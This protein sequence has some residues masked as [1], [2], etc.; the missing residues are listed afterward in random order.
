MQGRA[1]K[2]SR[3]EN[4]VIAMKISMKISLLGLGLIVTVL[5]TAVML[6]FI[7]LMGVDI[8]KVAAREFKNIS[9]DS[10]R[11]VAVDIRQMCDI[12]RLF[13]ESYSQGV[14]SAVVSA[15]E[16]FGPARL[17]SDEISVEAKNQYNPLQKIEA[18]VK[19]F[20]FGDT[21]VDPF[22]PLDSPQ[23]KLGS[24]L[25]R[26]KDNLKCDFTIF[27][28]INDSKNML[29]LCSTLNSEGA[30]PSAMTYFPET[31][32]SGDGNTAFSYVLS[33]RGYSGIMEVGLATL[34]ANYFPIFD[35]NGEVI[36]AVFY[37]TRKNSIAELEKYLRSYNLSLNSNSRIWIIDNSNE[38]NPVIKTSLD[39]SFAGVPLS[40]DMLGGRKKYL[41]DALSKAKSLRS[42]EIV[43]ENIADS[44]EGV[45][46]GKRIITYTYYRPWNWVIGAISTADAYNGSL[47]S[48]SLQISRLKRE[49]VG[50]GIFFTALALGLSWFFASK[51]ARPLKLMTRVA[52]A[53][54]RGDMQSAEDLLSNSSSAGRGGITEFIRL[55]DALLSMTRNISK[56][57]SSV[58]RTGEYTA[59][60]GMQISAAATRLESM[61]QAENDAI[62]K[63]SKKGKQIALSYDSLNKTAKNSVRGVSKT[64]F[65]TRLA[66]SSLNILK[67]NCDILSGVSEKLIGQLDAITKNVDGITNVATAINNVSVKTNLLSLNAS[68]EAERAGELGLGF[69]VVARRIRKLADQTSAASEKIEKN[70]RLMQSS[71]NSSV[72]EIDTFASKIRTSSRIILETAVSLS[73][74]I[75]DVESLGPKFENISD[76]LHLFQNVSELRVYIWKKRLIYALKKRIRHYYKPCKNYFAKK[77]LMKFRLASYATVPKYD[78]PLFINILPI[79]VNYWLI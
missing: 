71:V 57:I 30:S 20:Y 46:S 18:R 25:L 78:A 77:V 51:M 68:I 10:A 53:Q 34:S 1:S 70:V 65:R 62:T 40:S 63:V 76:I 13:D 22:V 61:S 17:G 69:A 4:A 6:A 11:Q 19:K 32:K 42:N 31:G 75:G 73:R 49:I 41:Y 16:E 58:K 48:I 60:R 28:K 67:Q 8:D 50:V 12:I 24:V 23:N 44:G 15:L 3:C 9:L 14:R 56:I 39:N 38:K 45:P 47:E 74:V 54:A 35:K 72:I 43:S 36:G 7:S 26:L 66:N 29:R 33:G 5:P 59:R 2:D 27:Q 79:K 52:R 21:H 64:L 55:F 37:G